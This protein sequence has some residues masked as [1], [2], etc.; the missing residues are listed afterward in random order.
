MF[1][2]IYKRKVSFQVIFCWGLKSQVA[3]TNSMLG[4]ANK[5]MCGVKSMLWATEVS[6]HS[7]DLNSVHLEQMLASMQVP[8]ICVFICNVMTAW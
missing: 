8:K 6:K 3:K 5:L 4:Y 2:T 1:Q 7:L